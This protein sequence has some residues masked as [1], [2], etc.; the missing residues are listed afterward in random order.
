[1]RY[2]DK[3]CLIEMNGP[4][5][6]SGLLR[7]YDPFMNL[8]LDDAFEVRASDKVSIGMIVGFS[9]LALSRSCVETLY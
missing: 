6:V 4:R 5:K 8:V 7:G 2:M 9:S 3:K 1:M